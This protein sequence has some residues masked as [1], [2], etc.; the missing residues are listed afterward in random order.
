MPGPVKIGRV[1]GVWGLKGHLKIEPLSD[2]PAR[3]EVGARVRVAGEWRVVEDARVHQGRP[4]LRLSGIQTVEEAR[5]LQW[6]YLEASGEPPPLEPGEYLTSDLIGLAVETEDGERLGAIEDVLKMPA[7][8]V[9]VVG[10][11]LIPA[12][13]EFVLDVDIEGGLVLVRL[14]EGMR[15]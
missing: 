8:D 1:V 9:L 10:E 7:H 5:A 12:R 14:I 13:R 3:F 15:P 11:L 2:F 6:E 4:Y